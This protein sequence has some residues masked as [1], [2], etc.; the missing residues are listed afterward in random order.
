MQKTLETTVSELSTA[1]HGL[2]EK[3]RILSNRDALLESHGLE[4]RKLSE[5]LE[6]E[7]SARRADRAQH[8]QWHKTTLHSTRTISQKDSRI[9]ELENNREADR[10]RLVALEREFKSQLVERN[11]LLLSLWNKLSSLCGTDWQNQNSLVSGHLPTP[12]VVQNLLPGF[13]KN[14]LLAVR[15]IESVI[16]GFKG[17][18]KAVEKDLMKDYQQLE[19]N[20]DLRIKRLDR[21]ESA[22]QHSRVSGAANAAPEI[23]KLRGENR[24]LKSDIAA[25]HKQ[26]QVLRSRQNA[27]SIE[28]I[29]SSSSPEKDRKDPASRAARAAAVS[30]LTRHYSSTAVETLQKEQHAAADAIILPSQPLDPSQARWIHR[31]KDLER[32]LKAEREARLQDRKGARERL[33]K[34]EEE[35]E[36][37]RAA[38]ERERQKNQAQ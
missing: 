14:L 24:L 4:S 3:D 38:L 16:G 5:L 15:T 11:S 31:L 28:P 10:K 30:S 34:G 36:E 7:R 2:S 25:L 13:S 35:R 6:K 20:L 23:A 29:G 37:L 27:V 21:L 32:R 18:I 8:E 17:K 12:D 19:H 22:V 1:R 26:E 9:G 33:E